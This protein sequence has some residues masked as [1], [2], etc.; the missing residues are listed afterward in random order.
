MQMIDEYA[1]KI[2]NLPTVSVLNSSTGHCS[3]FL[4]QPVYENSSLRILFFADSSI[5]KPI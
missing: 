4:L 5:L 1:E 2:V 3:S